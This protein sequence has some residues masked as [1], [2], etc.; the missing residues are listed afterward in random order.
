MLRTIG[1]I[2]WLFAYLICKV[3]AYQKAKKLGKRGKLQEQQTFVQQKTEQWASLL[4]RNVGVKVE[5]TGRENLP[6]NGETVVFA[7]NHQS[8]LDIPILL[9]NLDEPHA[10]M[11]KKELD[12]I[13]FLRGWMRILGCIYVDRDDA[14]ASIAALKKAEETLKEGRS[15]IVCPEGT[16]SKSD[17]M[18][19][20]K[21]GAVRMATRAGVPV[22][23]VA[24]DGSY[25]GLEGNG[26]KL[27]K[28]TVRLVILP[29]V[30][31]KNLTRDE[32]KALP[33]QLQEMVRVAKDTRP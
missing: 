6:Q 16:R 4:L 7:A 17:E 11:A 10:L 32:Q 26:F 9:A 8:Y 15:V 31:T 23:P 29:A 14:R 22:V 30:E 5:V 12:K 24:I 33:A 13:P 21:A 27:K 2:T 19:E 18:G 20:F 1:W 25:R 28:C 3:P